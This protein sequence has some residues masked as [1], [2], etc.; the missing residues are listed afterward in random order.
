[1]LNTIIVIII[2]TTLLTLIMY[3]CDTHVR[4]LQTLHPVTV[5]LHDCDDKQS[6]SV[7]ND[8]LA[9]VQKEQKLN[10]SIYRQTIFLVTEDVLKG[11]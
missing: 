1:M 9:S 8:R 7:E 5:F 3:L 6:I 10:Q 11:Q 4:Q 2:I